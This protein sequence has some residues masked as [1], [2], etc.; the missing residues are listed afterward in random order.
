M[1][2][3][4]YEDEITRIFSKM[5]TDVRAFLIYLAT[6]GVV[7]GAFWILATVQPPAEVVEKESDVTQVATVVTTSV[8]PTVS[9]E[10]PKK[11]AP[12]APET[13]TVNE[14]V[15]S[16]TP[17]ADDQPTT[18][19]RISNPY[20]TP[21]LP[22]LAINEGAR[23]AL[24]NILCST[25]GSTL[26]NS[27]GSGVIIDPRGIVLTNAHVAQYVLLAQSGRTNLSCIIR[28][29]APARPTWQAR[30]L[31]I[32]PVWI[33][34]H[35]EDITDTSPTGTGEHD[36]ALLRLVPLDEGGSAG[37]SA[38]PAL[39]T[40]SRDAIGFPGDP[41]LAASYPSEFVGVRAT[42]F[43]LHPASSI[44][45]IR[46]L[47]TFNERTVDLISLGGV[48]EAQS[49]S[50]GGAVVNA[51]G[52]LIGIITTTSEGTTT[53]ERELRALTLSYINRDFLEQ[54]GEDLATFLAGDPA[55]RETAFKTTH[56]DSL[57]TLLIEAIEKRLSR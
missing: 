4:L 2:D 33:R 30:V 40:D 42:Q 48:P 10:A 51:W 38:T 3:N 57:T 22:F 45:S 18:I 52:Y 54:S 15:P 37:L 43:N 27:S 24:L 19:V 25:E 53:A 34:E 28:T 1:W 14:V 26:H 49:G 56:A 21:P 39:P 29:G 7:G 12:T 20:D 6:I 5:S 11:T 47:L 17:A 9:P 44:T 32:P 50:S 41:I 36:Y 31:Y 23:A 55:D 16:P 13:H 46:E 8:P 35:A